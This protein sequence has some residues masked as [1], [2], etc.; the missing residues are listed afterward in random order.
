MKS[1]R[2]VISQM[3]RKDA[4]KSL[5][6]KY[7]Y[8]PFRVVT[9]QVTTIIISIGI[10]QAKQ[11]WIQHGK[12][13]SL[14]CRFFMEVKCSLNG[15]VGGS[16]TYE[17][18]DWGKNTEVIPLLHCNRE[19]VG[20]K[21]T[22]EIADVETE[23][24]LILVRASIFTFPETLLSWPFVPTTAQP[25]ALDGAEDRKGVRFLGIYPTTATNENGRKERGNS[26]P[27]LFIRKQ[28]YLFL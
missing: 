9:S 17:R 6:K 18:R 4:A 8:N 27:T 19:I 28:V 2:R 21:S 3:S 5:T 14:F 20:H 16:C 12:V 1:N 13:S 26:G 22:W 23:V 15:I 11:H 25:W 7:V 10:W 24:E